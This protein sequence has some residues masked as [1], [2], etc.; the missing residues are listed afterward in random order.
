MTLFYS[1]NI[2]CQ[3]ADPWSSLRT[4]LFRLEMFLPRGVADMQLDTAMR[5]IHLGSTKVQG[6]HLLPDGYELAF[7]PPDVEFERPS[8]RAAI[9]GGHAETIASTHSIPKIIIAASQ[10]IY[11]GTTLWQSRWDQIDRYGYAAFGLTVTP[12][13]VMSLIN[14][15]AQLL[16]PDYETLFLVTSEISDEAER[17]GGLFQGAVARLKPPEHVG[18]VGIFTRSPPISADSSPTLYSVEREASATWTVQPAS[19]LL[20]RH[21]HPDAVLRVPQCMATSEGCRY[22]KAADD[23]E[24]RKMDCS[25]LVILSSVF[26]FALLNILVVGGLSR[27]Q[28]GSSTL[29]QRAWAMTWLAEGHMGGMLGFQ[30]YILQPY[31]AMGSVT[32]AHTKRLNPGAMSSSSAGTR[33]L[34]S[35]SPLAVFFL[36]VLVGLPWAVPAIGG[37]VNVGQMLYEH[38]S[39][40]HI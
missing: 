36:N 10:I 17:R 27:F 5:A 24:W 9:A 21:H 38:G 34:R 19:S 18:P 28:A 23:R 39:C 37:F 29:A 30:A 3:I 4:K 33:F 12:Y 7:L 35:L 32:R 16:T 15:L 31:G 25:Y 22:D 26:F 2:L 14:L 13:L 1:R 8:D 40:T 6:T 20:E 11:A